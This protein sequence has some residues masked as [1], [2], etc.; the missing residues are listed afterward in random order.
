MVCEH[1]LGSTSN[2]RTLQGGGCPSRSRLGIT[3]REPLWCHVDGTVFL[4]GAHRVNR[5]G[6]AFSVDRIG[7]AYT[8]RNI[9]HLGGTRTTQGTTCAFSPQQRGEKHSD[10]VHLGLV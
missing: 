5:L 8:A 2:V 7:C 10:E 3:Y 9:P 4:F 6:V 1:A